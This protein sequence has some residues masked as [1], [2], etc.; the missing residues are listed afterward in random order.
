M[1]RPE[2]RAWRACLGA[3]AGAALALT[4]SPARAEPNLFA[5]TIKAAA[6]ALQEMNFFAQEQ[7]GFY[8]ISADDL[9]PGGLGV[10]FGGSV[11]GIGV[12]LGFALETYRGAP[13]GVADRSGAGGLG[14]LDVE[15]RPLPFLENNFYRVLDPYVFS[16]AEIGGGDLSFRAGQTIGAGLDVGLFSRPDTSRA[17]VHP[18][19]TFRYEYRLWQVPE[20]LPHHL[21][22]IGAVTR[23]V[24]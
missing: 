19:L 6:E 1:T 11:R 8:A 2:R 3:A 18:A 22:S 14:R 23:V 24:F 17:T 16:A 10:R 4:A 9:R 7:A 5:E 12:G 21:L 20:P 13:L 15:F